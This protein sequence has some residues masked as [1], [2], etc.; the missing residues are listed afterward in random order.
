M[1]LVTIL[2]DA[3]D[4]EDE[5]ANIVAFASLHHANLAGTPP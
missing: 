2:D 1:G 4:E 3:F 5:T